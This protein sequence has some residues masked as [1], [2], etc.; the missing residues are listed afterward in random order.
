MIPR[1]CAYFKL[2]HVLTVNL[3]VIA[4]AHADVL[5]NVTTGIWQLARGLL[6]AAYQIST[7]I[8]AC[9]FLLILYIAQDAVHFHTY[10]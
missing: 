2:A 10:C 8:P 9:F 7:N 3:S 5:P 1:L 4:V 6:C